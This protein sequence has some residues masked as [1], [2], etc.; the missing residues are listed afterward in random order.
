MER[1]PLRLLWRT[2]RLAHGIIG[3]LS[4]LLAGPLALALI[5]FHDLVALLSAPPQ[6]APPPFLRITTTLPQWMSG[7]QL[8]LLQGWSLARASFIDLTIALLVLCVAV[9]LLLGAV[10]LAVQARRAGRALVDLTDRLSNLLLRAQPQADADVPALAARALAGLAAL[11]PGLNGGIALPALALATALTA[12][13]ALAVLSIW[14]VPA[15]LLL[16]A[17]I[18]TGDVVSRRLAE[19]MRLDR[20]RSDETFARHLQDRLARWPLL[21]AHGAVATERAAL[22]ALAPPA[23]AG[24]PAL[25][26]VLLDLA[27]IIL[28]LAGPALVALAP[29]LV[30]IRL[31]PADWITAMMSAGLLSGATLVLASS[32]ERLTGARFHTKDLADVFATLRLVKGPVPGGSAGGGAKAGTPLLL[33][34]AM[35]LA[36]P[37]RLIRIDIPALEIPDARDL[38]L[39]STDADGAEFVAATWAGLRSL[40]PETIRLAGHDPVALP[41]EA[42]AIAIGYVARQ[43]LL[44]NRSL[45]DNLLYGAPAS[46]ADD[47]RALRHVLSL[48][49]LAEHAFSRA[50]A[51]PLNGDRHRRLSDAVAP[52]RREIVERIRDRALSET[53]LAESV[54]PFDPSRFN[55]HATIAENIL[56]GEPV[57]DTF[58]TRNLARHPFFRAVLEAE[59]LTRIF[60]DKGYDIAEATLEMFAGIPDDHPLFARFAFFPADQRDEIAAIVGHG[61]QRRRGG[62]GQ[63]ERD[64]LIGLTLGYIESRHRLGLID[65]GLEARLV[66]ARRTFASLLPPALRPAIDLYDPDRVCRPASLADNLLFGRVAYDLAGASARSRKL[67]RELIDRHGLTDA[68]LDLGLDAPPVGRMDVA[69]PALAWRIDLGRCLLREPGMLVLARVP[70]EIGPSELRELSATLRADRPQLRILW[71]L[72]PAQEFASDGAR[73]V[74]ENATLRNEPAT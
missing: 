62:E 50:L 35:R 16:A 38:F 63:R 41:L 3:A 74:L 43:P 72:D 67:L 70:T 68:V 61:R 7:D 66:G 12:I 21:R 33:T 64:R 59:D 48:T 1:R 26:P 49:G 46:L 30:G 25:P 52:L 20:E 28:L 40:A 11:R 36:A 73:L 23:A 6:V 34:P 58:G 22:A 37:E 56:F 29:A 10:I 54:D 31:S 5:L 42:R 15:A 69:S 27:R 39:V 8:V 17:L 57:G 14:L 45:A 60:V 24:Q 44:L 13:I 55:R 19:G 53:A 65:A 18:V 32:R 2:D 71:G 51:S 9:T 4:L 47:R